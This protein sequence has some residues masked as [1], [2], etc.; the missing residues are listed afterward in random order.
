MQ[1]QLMEEKDV[2]LE[3]VR[4]LLDDQILVNRIAQEELMEYKK[5]LIT[6]TK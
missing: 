6:L 3:K 2:E 4:V 5:Q 1:V